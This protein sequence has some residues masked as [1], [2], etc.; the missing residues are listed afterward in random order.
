M[1]TG[2]QSDT[3]R[4]AEARGGPV[5]GDG[6]HGRTPV[7]SEDA[8]RTHTASEDKKRTF[9]PREDNWRPPSGALAVALA[10]PSR[11]G[12]WQTVTWPGTARGKMLIWQ[13]AA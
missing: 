7:K 2:G 10:L 12:V 1:K 9:F 5:Q 11:T 8:Q 4:T 13:L 6:G 3:E